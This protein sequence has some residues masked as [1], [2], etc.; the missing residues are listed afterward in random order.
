MFA[1]QSSFWAQK[2]WLK[3]LPGFLFKFLGFF[4]EVQK[5]PANS[6][7]LTQDSSSSVTFSQESL[8]Q[9]ADSPQWGLSLSLDAGVLGRVKVSQENLTN[10][11]VLQKYF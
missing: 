4:P 7:P 10:M 1:S 8:V 11:Y 3:H 5:N 9:E 2:L 6:K